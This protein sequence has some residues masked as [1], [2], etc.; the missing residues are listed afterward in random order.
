VAATDE[1]DVGD[2]GLGED[3]AEGPRVGL[4]AVALAVDQSVVQMTG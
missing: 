1:A 3:L 4:L 2:E